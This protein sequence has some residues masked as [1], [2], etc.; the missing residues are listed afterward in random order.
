MP[1]SNTLSHSVTTPLFIKI[2]IAIQQMA[3]HAMFKFLIA[4]TSLLRTTVI[5]SF[6]R[7]SIMPGAATTDATGLGNMNI[8]LHNIFL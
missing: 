5:I 8:T 1:Q 6:S 4:A 2:N 3:S 7:K